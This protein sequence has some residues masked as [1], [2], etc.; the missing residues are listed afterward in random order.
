MIMSALFII[1]WCILTWT[2]GYSFAYNYIKNDDIKSLIKSV[3]FIIILVSI[4]IGFIYLYNLPIPEETVKF[5]E[6]HPEYIDT[7]SHDLFS[8]LFRLV[9]LSSLLIVIICM[10]FY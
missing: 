3:I 4:L 7:T 9:V 6:E 10:A 5:F 1:I 8:E 2:F